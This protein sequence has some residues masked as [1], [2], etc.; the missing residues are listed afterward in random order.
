[1]PIRVEIYY[2]LELGQLLQYLVTYNTGQRRMDLATQ[3]EIMREP[4]IRK[5]QSKDAA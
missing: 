2:N 3:L 1:M 5:K 4:L